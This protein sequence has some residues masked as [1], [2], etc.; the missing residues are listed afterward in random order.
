MAIEAPEHAAAATFIHIHAG[1]PAAWSHAQYP[2]LKMIEI[3][4]RASFMPYE[5]VHARR[6][7]S[8][9]VQRSGS[10]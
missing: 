6:Q 5:I 8:R 10:L 2:A 9:T 4:K 7:A 3:D 1:R